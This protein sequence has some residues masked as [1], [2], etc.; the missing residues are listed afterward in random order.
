M[1]SEASSECGFELQ[2]DSEEV[3]DQQIELE[4]LVYISMQD[5][6]KDP[7]KALAGFEK[8]L[9]LEQDKG[10][11]GFK[12]LAEIVKIRIRLRQ[13]E[14]MM[15]AYRQLLG[16]IQTAVTRNTSET[17]VNA[18]LDLVG[19]L[20]AEEATTLLDDFFAI[21]LEALAQTNNERLW[22]KTKL[23]LGKTYFVRKA[24]GKMQRVIREL[25]KH[26]RDADGSVIEQKSSQMLEL[27][28][29]EIQLC[30]ETKDSKRLHALYQRSLQIRAALAHPRIIG[31]IRECGGKMHMADRNWE[32]AH[33]D[34]FEAF[35]C[36]NEAGDRRKLECLKYLVIANMLMVSDINPF[37]SNEAKAYK[38]D[39]QIVAMTN[40][41]DAYQKSD[42]ATFD[43]VLNSNHRAI[44]SD[45]F[46]NEYVVELRRT[47]R[48]NVLL[49]T[50]KPYSRVGV[51]FLAS[52]LGVDAPGVEDLLVA[53]ILDGRLDA[54][55]D[56]VRGMVVVSDTSVEA[57]QARDAARCA[58]QRSL[59][60]S[61]AKL[62][63]SLTS[64]LSDK[65]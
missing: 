40:L 62:T 61:L 13:F 26:C 30:T 56:Q 36:Y 38:D 16:Y 4:N 37:D 41:I 52:T 59:T 53:V 39:P 8:A 57:A 48:T 17:V 2:S 46:V 25:D 58:A 27:L 34:F 44:T 19:E 47:I 7:E 43:R 65:P 11:W 54:R 15:N 64:R 1:S 63:I 22:F 9:T 5:V 51:G 42:L 20:P 28:A 49:A 18:V 60:A 24:Y 10:E 14:A 35:K 33:Q 31:I 29:L 55:I 50:L 32:L 6:E 23:K 3:D 21:T 45:A 12:A